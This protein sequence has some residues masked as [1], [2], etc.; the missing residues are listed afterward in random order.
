MANGRQSTVGCTSTYNL[1]STA[2]I[3]FGPRSTDHSS[4]QIQVG[5]KKMWSTANSPRSIAACVS[6]FNLL[7]TVD[8][9]LLTK[10]PGN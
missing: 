9:G 3:F 4:Q 1:L 7:S 8:S 2:A 6:K 5:R 10:A